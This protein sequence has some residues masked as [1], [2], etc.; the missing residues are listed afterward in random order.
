MYV[1]SGGALAA[2]GRIL[3]AVG[4][5]GLGYV[6]GDVN[7]DG[8]DDLA[9]SHAPSGDEGEVAVPLGGAG[10]LA[11][12]GTQVVVPQD[13]GAKPGLR[14]NADHF[15]GWQLYLADLDTDGDDDLVV[16]TFRAGD[17]PEESGYWIFRGTPEGMSVADREFVTTEDAG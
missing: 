11:V 10:G 1:R 8:T 12:D 17:P 13:V 4:R 6:A 2:S 9:T 5:V 3:A 7:G 16:G 15:F 14:R